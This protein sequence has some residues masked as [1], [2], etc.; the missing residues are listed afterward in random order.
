M[1]YRK[2]KVLRYIDKTGKGIE[3]GPSHL[4]IAPK[5]EGFKVDIIDHLSRDQL[6]AK[7]KDHHVNL[8]NIEEVDFVWSGESYSEL[9]GKTKYYDW[10]IASHVIEHT[11]DLIGF[12]NDCDAVLKDEGVLSLVIPD[13]RYC[14]DHFRPITGISKIIDH[15]FQK[16]TIHSSGTVAEYFL[17]IVLRSGQ[18]TWHSNT[19]EEYSFIHSLENARQGIKSVVNEK[20]YLDVHAWCFT[21]HSFRLI[22]HDLFSLGLIAF[23]EVD[24]FPT[25]G[26][27]FYVTLGRKGKGIDQPRIEMLKMIESEIKDY[28]PQVNTQEIKLPE[29]FNPDIYLRLNPDVAESKIDPEE[30]Y[31]NFGIKEGRKYR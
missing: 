10:M 8:D 22:I 1:R 2:E 19:P 6:V 25:D 24:F 5:K 23:Q 7:F 3:V 16:A 9:T 31:L 28:Q 4:P 27:E 18:M 20:A 14:F 26:F 30:H 13:K 15:H 12:L 17:N 29:D 21:P 11:P